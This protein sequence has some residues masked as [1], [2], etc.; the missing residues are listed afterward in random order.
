MPD[1]IIE[2]ENTALF[3]GQKMPITIGKNGFCHVSNKIEGDNKTPYVDLTPV[4]F[5]YRADRVRRIKSFLPTFAI[6][7]HDGWCDAPL[8]T[9]YNQY[10]TLPYKA[11]AE[12][13][14]RTDHRY[15]YILVTDYNYPNAAPYGGSA[16]FI[17]IMHDDMTPTA[18]CIGFQCYDL[19]RII[20][21]L[22]LGDRFR[23]L[24]STK[25]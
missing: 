8:D 11:S 20:A 10:V 22:T 25:P 16:I 19:K 14:Y 13:L 2:S 21:C 15:D 7:K 24:K 6:H 23:L 4:A 17:H 3:M 1:I 18:G 5:F 9:Q 12:N